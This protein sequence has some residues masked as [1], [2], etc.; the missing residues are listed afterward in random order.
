[1]RPARAR[2]RL[3]PNDTLRRSSRCPVACSRRRLKSSTCS[4]AASRKASWVRSTTTTSQLPRSA[5]RRCL[6]RCCPVLSRCRRTRPASLRCRWRRGRSEN[7][8]NSPI[9]E[10]SDVLDERRP[11]SGDARCDYEQPAD[12]SVRRRYR[13]DSSGGDGFGRSTCRRDGAPRRVPGGVRRVMMLVSTV[14]TG[15]TARRPARNSGAVKSSIRWTMGG[16]RGIR[17]ARAGTAERCQ[18]NTT[19]REASARRR[20]RSQPEVVA[21]R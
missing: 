15:R 18:P 3:G 2:T 12:A 17:R 10:T 14:G 13:T 5:S 1:M 21:R 7:A 9:T 6:S 11:G 20:R 4:P 19:R 16:G 8:P